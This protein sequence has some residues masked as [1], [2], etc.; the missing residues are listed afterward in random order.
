MAMYSVMRDTDD[1]SRQTPIKHTKLGCCNVLEEGNIDSQATRSISKRLINM[2]LLTGVLTEYNNGK[3]D[4]YYRLIKY[5]FT[6]VSAH[7]IFKLEGACSATY[8]M[9]AASARDC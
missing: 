5:M 7:F 9:I 4:K 8:V 3:I 2:V 1:S 6:T